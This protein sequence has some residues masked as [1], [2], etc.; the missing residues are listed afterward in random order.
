MQQKI[1]YELVFEWLALAVKE[2]NEITII[3][4]FERTGMKKGNW[5]SWNHLSPKLKSFF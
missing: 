1:N 3:R 5:T 4:S 2:I